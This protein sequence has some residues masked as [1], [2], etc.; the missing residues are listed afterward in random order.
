[1]AFRYKHTFTGEVIESDTRLDYLEG[2]ARWEIEEFDGAAKRPDN[3]DQAAD[4]PNAG[5]P[6]MP[7]KDAKKV[8]WVEWAKS[9]G[10]TDDDLKGLT[11][12]DIAEKYQDVEADPAETA[13]GAPTE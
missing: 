3:Q 8:E 5:D 9:K 1:M 10:A 6:T 12:A 11:I 4:D 7:A 2:M 13:D